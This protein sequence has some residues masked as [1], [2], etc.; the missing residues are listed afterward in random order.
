MPM[1]CLSCHKERG[2]EFVVGVLLCGGCA[3][4][5]KK[6][7]IELDREI[8]R[9][10]ALTKNWLQQHIMKGGLFHGNEREAQEHAAGLLLGEGAVQPVRGQEEVPPE[11][12]AHVPQG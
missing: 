1:Q 9:A 12:G 11:P 7:V 2:T 5:A 10:K 3:P 6:I 8:E 4:V